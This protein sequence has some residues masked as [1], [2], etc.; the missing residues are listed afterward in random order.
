MTLTNS[1]NDMTKGRT[2]FQISRRADYAIR[3]MLD[4][5]A[6]PAGERARAGEV[7]RR[8]SA[9]LPFLHKITADLVRAG[10][11]ETHAG[12]KGGLSLTRPPAAITLLEIIQAV[13]GP[14]ALNVCLVRPHECPRSGFCPAHRALAGLQRSLVQQME[15][16]TLAGLVADGKILARTPSRAVLPQEIAIG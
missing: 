2:L 9:P 3:V 10:L 15:A 11:V 16:I 4:V 7:A 8:M 14:I 5:G 1:V 13:E 12:P 6:L